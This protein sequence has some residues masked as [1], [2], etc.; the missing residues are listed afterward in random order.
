[1][2]FSVL[3]IFDY[4]ILDGRGEK[5]KAMEKS[6]FHGMRPMAGKWRKML[7]VGSVSSDPFPEPVPMPRVEGGC[8]R[9]GQTAVAASP[10]SKAARQAAHLVK[11]WTLSVPSQD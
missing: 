8:H 7:E 6:T 11:T 4:N 3:C 9:W 10:H 2:T 1:M 5:R